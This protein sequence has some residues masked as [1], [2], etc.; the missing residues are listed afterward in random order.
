MDQLLSYIQY[1]KQ[2]YLNKKVNKLNWKDFTKIN[3]DVFIIT[4]LKIKVDID[5]DYLGLSNKDYNINVLAILNYNTE[6][7][8]NIDLLKIID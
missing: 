7:I 2:K 5:P 1:V 4:S 3:D 8:F 6:D